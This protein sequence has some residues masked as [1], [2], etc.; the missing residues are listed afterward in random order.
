[1]SGLER[2][3]D[4]LDAAAQIERLE[5]LGVRDGLVPDASFRR[6]ERVLRP[7]AGVVEAGCH[8]V[9]VLH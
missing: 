5:R 3:E 7:D 4:P 6:E 2:G 8:R 9:G 1:M